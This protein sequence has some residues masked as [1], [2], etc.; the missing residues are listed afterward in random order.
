MNDH[1][2]HDDSVVPRIEQKLDDLIEKFDDHLRW[3][4]EQVHDDGQRITRLEKVIDHIEYP[5]K[6]VGWVVCGT[7]T[8]FL[9]YFGTKFGEWISRHC[10]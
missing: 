5:V 6:V 7:L 10:N 3:A 8:G 9:L 4:N 1:Q 2:R